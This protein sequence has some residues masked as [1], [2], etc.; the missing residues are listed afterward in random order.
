MKKTI[1]L[2]LLLCV[3]GL[4]AG[5]VEAKETIKTSKQKVSINQKVSPMKGYLIDNSNYFKLRDFAK[6]I[7]ETGQKEFDVQWL[8][9]ERAIVIVPEQDYSALGTELSPVAEKINSL[10]KNSAK[11][12]MQAIPFHLEAYNINGYN[13]FKL[14]DLCALL[15]IGVTYD[16]A[17]HEVKIDTTKNYFQTA[18]Q[19]LAEMKEIKY[20]SVQNLA[21]GFSFEIPTILTALPFFNDGRLLTLYSDSGTVYDEDKESLY[22]Y[23]SFHVYQKEGKKTLE[24]LLQDLATKSEST[25]KKVEK[26]DAK[27]KGAKRAVEW[28]LTDEKETVLHFLAAEKNNNFYLVY[29]F[30]SNGKLINPAF[31][32]PLRLTR[33]HLY[34]SLVID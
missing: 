13:Y 26:V 31:H 11:L 18:Y 10:H 5:K 6:V 24:D 33:T 29:F 14:R 7:S 30:S 22:T 32:E 15:G 23:L 1:L 4:S 20:T 8:E 12:M 3:L 19:E 25:W 34:Q 9:E 16:A 27:V 2:L 17:N 28:T 21:H